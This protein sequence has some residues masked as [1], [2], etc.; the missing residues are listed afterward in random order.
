MTEDALADSLHVRF[1]Q[2]ICYEDNATV[3]WATAIYIQLCLSLLAWRSVYSIDCCMQSASA[4][5]YDIAR[6]STAWMYAWNLKLGDFGSA[7]ICLYEMYKRYLNV[8]CWIQGYELYLRWYQLLNSS[9]MNEILNSI[10][11]LYFLLISQLAVVNCMRLSYMIS[12]L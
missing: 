9:L 3:S 10:Y 4:P 5:R 1:H 6:W 7:I 8:K 11:I 2:F 12:S